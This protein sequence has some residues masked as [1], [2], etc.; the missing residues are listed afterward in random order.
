[1][2]AGHFEVVVGV[3]EAPSDPLRIT[4]INGEDL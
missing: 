1:M 3:G 4:E 2:H